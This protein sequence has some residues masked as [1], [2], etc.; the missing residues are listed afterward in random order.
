MTD[1]EKLKAVFGDLDIGYEVE[2]R[3]NN[4]IILLEAKTHKNVGGYGG[5]STEFIFDE[6]EKSKGVSIWE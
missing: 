3:E 6:N 4:K 5:F 1:F 2:E